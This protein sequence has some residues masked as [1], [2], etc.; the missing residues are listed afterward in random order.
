MGSDRTMQR[1]MVA[2]ADWMSSNQLRLH[3]YNTQFISMATRQQLAK[4]NLDALSAEFLTM[5]LSSVVRDLGIILDSEFTIGLDIDQVCRSCYCQS[6]QLRVIS[7]SL[8]VNSAV[9]L[10]HAFEFLTIAV[11]YSL[12]LPGIREAEAGP[13]AASRLIGRVA[14]TELVF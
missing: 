7:R 9:S 5:R 12:S 14:V 2:L 13:S 10:L 1:K 6:K 4:L 11:P 3:V 8:T